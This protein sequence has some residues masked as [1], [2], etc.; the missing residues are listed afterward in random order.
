MAGTTLMLL[1]KG[2]FRSPKDDRGIGHRPRI[3]PFARQPNPPQQQNTVL[4]ILTEASVGQ[5]QKEASDGR[6]GQRMVQVTS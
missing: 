4:Q 3:M 2:Y 1:N 6:H 5:P